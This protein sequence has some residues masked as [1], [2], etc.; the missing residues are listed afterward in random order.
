MHRLTRRQSLFAIAGAASSALAAPSLVGAQALAPI[1]MGWT[2][3]ENA[4]QAYYGV[5]QGFF[6]KAGIDAQLT[7]FPNSQAISNAVAANAIDIG[8]ADMIQ[9]ASGYLHGVPFGFFAGA[10]VY[11]SEVPTLELLCAKESPYK[12]AR[13]LEGQT[14]AVIA[15]NSI[16]AISV[17]EWLKQNGADPAKVKIFEMPFPTMLPGLQ[18]GTIAAAL[19]AEPF[20]TQAVAD[21]RVLGKTYDAVAKQFYITS[22]FG[23]RDWFRKNPELSKR[24]RDAVYETAH[25]QNT[26]HAETAAILS[27]LTKI[28]VEQ[29]RAM[30]RAGMATSLDVKLMQPVIDIAA[31]YK[32][33]DRSVNAADL[34]ITL[35]S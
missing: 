35:P 30:N 34:V 5:D 8:C 2:A 31:R 3:S 16:S 25:W 28:P 9:L 26:H 6:A 27:K 1:R 18:R 20:M 24:L 22:W 19:F 14:V 7:V 4:A 15:L 17:Q 10:A 29:L 32:V 33:L 12:T 11:T 23:P 21:C 13:D